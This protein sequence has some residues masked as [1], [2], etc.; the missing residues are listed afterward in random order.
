MITRRFIAV[1]ITAAL[2]CSA[3]I[4]GFSGDVTAAS[5]Q[6]TESGSWNTTRSTVPKCGT[7]DA[8]SIGT[9]SGSISQT[10]KAEIVSGGVH[11][12]AFGVNF[13]GGDVASCFAEDLV[14]G[15]GP[16][17]PDSSG[18]AT[19]FKHRPTVVF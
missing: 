17:A 15:G 8:R 16:G 18:C 7:R 12:F 14:V 11:A 3:A 2:L 9:N 1:G 10:L 4:V 5:C 13:Q 19:V 6:G